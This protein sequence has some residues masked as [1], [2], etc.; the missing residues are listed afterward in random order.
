MPNKKKK[1]K[2][3]FVNVTDLFFKDKEED[4]FP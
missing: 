2:E 1:K 3:K 4:Y